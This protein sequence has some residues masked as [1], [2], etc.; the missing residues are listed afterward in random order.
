MLVGLVQGADAA[1][2]M[3]AYLSASARIR[4]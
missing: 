4:Q 2:A 3:I 1:A